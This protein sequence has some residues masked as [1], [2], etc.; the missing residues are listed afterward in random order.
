MDSPRPRPTEHAE[1]LVADALALANWKATTVSADA[2]EIAEGEPWP[3][4]DA[5]AFER[6]T[7]TVPAAWPLADV[8]LQLDVGADGVAILHSRLGVERHPIGPAAPPVRAPTRA[9]GLRI[10]ARRASRAVDDGTGGPRL[11][12]TQL[13]LLEAVASGGERSPGDPASTGGG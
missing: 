10:E 6:H 5:V 9:F 8:R 11:G 12:T 3:P 7:V 13:V 2:V 4:G 1:R